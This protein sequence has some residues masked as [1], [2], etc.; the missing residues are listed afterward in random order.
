MT[1][2]Q[3]IFALFPSS[4][5][6]I[7]EALHKAKKVAVVGYDIHVDLSEAITLPESE[8]PEKVYQFKDRGGDMTGTQAGRSMP[9]KWHAPSSV[10]CFSSYYCKGTLEGY[11]MHIEGK[12]VNPHGGQVDDAVFGKTKAKKNEYHMWDFGGFS[13]DPN[14]ENRITVSP[15]KDAIQYCYLSL[16]E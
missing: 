8:F 12:K 15:R 11:K 5:R 7:M 1:A 3:Q 4:M 13:S 6:G 2:E 10:R 16:S 9:M 14:V